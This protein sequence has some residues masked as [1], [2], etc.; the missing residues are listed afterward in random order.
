MSPEI[1]NLTF[2]EPNR[3]S[4]K[5]GI[6][7]SRRPL[8]SQE[9]FRWNASQSLSDVIFDFNCTIANFF[10]GYVLCPLRPPATHDCPGFPT[11]CILAPT[12]QWLLVLNY[13]RSNREDVSMLTQLFNATDYEFTGTEWTTKSINPNGENTAARTLCV[14]GTKN[15]WTNVTAKATATATEP[16]FGFYL[17]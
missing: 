7:F 17:S 8:E 16:V 4:G 12:N 9:F 3:I 2:R 10:D 5:L 13:S 15:T 11:S 1:K 14:S 6:D